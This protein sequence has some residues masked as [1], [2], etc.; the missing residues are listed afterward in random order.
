MSDCFIVMPIS[1]IDPSTYSND[2]DHFHHV[3]N[4][5]FIPAIK[6][7]GMNPVPPLA[8]GSDVIH[9]EIIRNIERSDLVLC[10]MSSLNPNVFFE[11]GIRTAVNKPVCIVKDDITPKIPFDTSIVNYHTYLSSLTPWTIER[12]IEDLVSHI[13]KSIQRSDGQNTMWRYFGLSTRAELPEG[14]TPVDD[15]LELLSLQIDS[16]N[17]KF[18]ESRFQPSPKKRTENPGEALFHKLVGIASASGL[19]VTTG[20]WSEK[21]MKIVIDD[22]EPQNS[23]MN[24]MLSTAL[25]N[26]F[27]LEIQNKNEIS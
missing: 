14:K 17:Q 8:E 12:Q 3:L 26:G 21:A 16:L 10:D 25:E 7:I 27:L 9:A 24:E 20:E 5:L 6:K 4:F 13:E 11:L 1:T 19:T 2:T 15:R 18:T 22:G 23:T